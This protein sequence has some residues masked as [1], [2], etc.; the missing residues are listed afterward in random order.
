M[1]KE[2][3]EFTTTADEDELLTCEEVCIFF[4]GKSKPLNPA[5][6]Y[7]GIKAEPPRYPKPIKI[8]PQISRWLLSECKEFRQRLLDARQ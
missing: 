4:G 2:N 7:K 5:T 8:G 6:L 1:S 3:V